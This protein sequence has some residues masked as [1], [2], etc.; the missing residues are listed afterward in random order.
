M[1]SGE[2]LITASRHLNKPL[3]LFWEMTPAC[4]NASLAKF[5]KRSTKRLSL[6]GHRRETT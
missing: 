5:S 1:A 3:G 4:A 6:K 2:P